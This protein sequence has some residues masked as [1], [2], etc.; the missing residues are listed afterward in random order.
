MICFETFSVNDMLKGITIFSEI[1]FTFIVN[2]NYNMLLVLLLY[3]KL[4]VFKFNFIYFSVFVGK[5]LK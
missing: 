1:K 2:S 3:P 4:T 5:E